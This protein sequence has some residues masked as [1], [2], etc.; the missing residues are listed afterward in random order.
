MKKTVGIISLALCAMFVQPAQA[1]DEKVIA[2]IDT[3]IDSSKFKNIVYEVCFTGNA[4]CPNNSN[5]QEGT[6]AANVSN[7]NATGMGHGYNIVYSAVKTNP[8]IKIVFIRI[9]NLGPARTPIAFNEGRSLDN[10]IDWVAKNASKYSI[11]AVSISQ[12]RSN[13]AAGTCPSNPVFESSVNALIKL[14][15]ATFVATGNDSL[16]NSIGFPSCVAGVNPVGAL[17]PLGN[18]ASF[19]NN[20]PK[21]KIF[22]NGCLEYS[23]N[24]CVKT[25]DFAGVMRATSGTSVATPVA[26]T[27]LVTRWN[28]E[29]W[30]TFLGSLSTGK[31]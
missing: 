4:T 15:V 26:V 29:N 25:P 23:G 22:A 11:D 30:L 21:V 17:D 5:F 13:F 20:S 27:K 8:D 2:I 31:L 9:S 7:W 24:I 18:V 6:G 16:K 14:N 10:A 19:S 12:S 1:A 28:G 3:A